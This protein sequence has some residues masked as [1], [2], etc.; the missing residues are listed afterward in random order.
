MSRSSIGARFASV[1]GATL[2]I[3][4]LFSQAA[5][6]LAASPG[7]RTNTAWSSSDAAVHQGP[8]S[9]ANVRK[10]A[11]TGASKLPFDPAVVGKVLQS[12]ESAAATT[13]KA[14]AG[15]LPNVAAPA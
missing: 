3:A 14:P 11:A 10:L 2:L 15:A 8:T 13:G 1:G 9:S 4:G 7:A 12:V 6:A 5:P